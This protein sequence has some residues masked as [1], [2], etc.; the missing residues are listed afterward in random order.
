[1]GTAQARKAC[2]R[3]GSHDGLLAAADFWHGIPAA[4]LCK[5]LF[6]TTAG[7]PTEAG[8]AAGI[9]GP[10][11]TVA[12]AALQAEPCHTHGQTHSCQPASPPWEWTCTLDQHAVEVVAPA[13][14]R[15]ALVDC[16]TV[17]AVY[18]SQTR[19]L[20]AGMTRALRVSPC[21]CIRKLKT[22]CEAGMTWCHAGVVMSGQEQNAP[23]HGGRVRMNS[24]AP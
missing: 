5:L 22:R 24:G 13:G 23:A 11:G 4:R 9:V 19:G 20:Y 1:M 21:W 2:L 7:P 6:C 16:H 3:T 12:S 17:C 14:Q 8:L 18:I 15:Q 10:W